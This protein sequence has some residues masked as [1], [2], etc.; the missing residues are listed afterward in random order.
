MTGDDDSDEKDSGERKDKSSEISSD[1]RFEKFIDR[2]DERASNRDPPEA[3]G[4]DQTAADTEA[5]TSEP[6]TGSETDIEDWI[7]GSP[8][9]SHDTES[10]E[11]NVT[12]Q[13][14][15]DE[16]PPSDSGSDGERIWDA[17]LG[18]G[19]DIIKRARESVGANE[20]PQ[21]NR[22]TQGTEEVSS[23]TDEL[24]DGSE[25][26][27]GPT[28]RDRWSELGG[29]LG[30]DRD[31]VR[32]TASDQRTS[33]EELEDLLEADR[34]GSDS[35]TDGL[36]WKTPEEG[37]DDQLSSETP[38]GSGDH[39]EEL[40]RIMGATSVLLLG[41]TGNSVSDAICSRFLVGE[42]G[43]HDVIFVT[44]DES[45]GERISVCSRADG[46]QGGEIGVIE[47]GRGNR[48][49]ATVSETTE[50]P[51]G[52][53]ITIKQVSRAGDLSKLGIVI[54][55]LLAE[56]ETT[57]RR[58]VLCFHTLSALHNQ[59]GTKTLFR[60]LNTLQGRLRASDAIGHYHMNPDLHDEIV[61]ETL[62]PIFDSIVEYSTDGEL[63]IE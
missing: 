43:P 62:R 33:S 57:P 13:T 63:R 56:F 50:S 19:L 24:E 20:G 32:E 23:D 53:S 48:N 5:G 36:P 38:I 11:P 3:G 26:R 54:S 39:S 45:P 35:D 31:D 58:T 7:W 34:K 60:F 2:L 47:V 14:E 17:P 25:P 28:E 10:S 6:D 61:I 12:P 59:I 9:R 49:T 18:D 21:R 46:W 15:T 41:P 40:G 37:A 44:F 4:D 30:E 27:S 55:Q 22:T 16:E 42:E 51:G 1:S 29:G 8:K 52:G